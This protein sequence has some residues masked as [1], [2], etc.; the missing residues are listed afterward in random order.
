MN[1]VLTDPPAPK[2]MAMIPA[3]EVASAIL[4]YQA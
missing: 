3:E 2:C 4:R 1:P